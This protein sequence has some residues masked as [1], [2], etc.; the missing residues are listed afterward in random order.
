VTINPDTLKLLLKRDGRTQS[1]VAEHAKVSVKT[2]RRAL[3]GN[4]PNKATIDRLG[5]ALGTTAQVL[6]GTPDTMKESIAK[7]LGFRRV[8]AFIRGDCFVSYELV[9]ARYGVTQKALIQAAPL[10]L[11]L[12]AEMS[13]A[14]RRARLAAFGEAWAALESVAPGHLSGMGRADN[15]LQEAFDSET[16]SIAASDISG[17]TIDADEFSERVE[18]EGDDLFVLFLRKLAGD[19]DGSDIGLIWGGADEINYD[20]LQ[21]DLDRVTHSDYLAKYA[22]GGGHVRLRDVPD[23][24]RGDDLGPERAAWLAAKVPPDARSEWEARQSELQDLADDIVG[25]LPAAPE[26][27]RE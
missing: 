20:V 16:R 6:G 22:L 7:R 27:D 11:T 13:L 25:S 24:L 3:K 14:D 2:L 10:L 21:S 15:D 18:R 8:S 1:E 17:S 9:E 12:L 26:T 5:I 19:L 23:E 4:N